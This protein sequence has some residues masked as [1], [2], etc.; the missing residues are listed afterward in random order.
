MLAHV[1]ERLLDDAVDLCFGL[2]VQ[3]QVA[4][5][6]ADVHVQDERQIGGHSLRVG[7]CGGT[8]ALPGL[9]RAAEA[10]DRLAHVH[11]H[12]ARGGAQLG[13]LDSRLVHAAV[14]Q[15]PVDRLRLGVHVA[16]DLGDPIVELAGDPLPL[17]H[18]RK[19]AEPVLK[20]GV[21]EGD[22][23]VVRQGRKRL[24]L[25][26][27]VPARGRTA[28]RE[29]SDGLAA[30]LERSR[31]PDDRASRVHEREDGVGGLGARGIP[32]GSLQRRRRCGGGE[33]RGCQIA[34][35]G[36]AAARS[37]RLP[38]APSRSKT[39]TSAPSSSRA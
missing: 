38:S 7:L 15:V 16:E 35:G 6:I 13:D 17:L 34:P 23:G 20:T 37:S 18:D 3:A 28:D 11:V 27:I 14:R 39:A 29:Q 31:Q 2:R 33:T 26:R 32:F 1:G 4:D 19:L 30:S 21:L 9:D 5:L 12:G 22:G 8:Q 36:P 25:V 24:H 10:K